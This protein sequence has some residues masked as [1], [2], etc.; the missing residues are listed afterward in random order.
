MSREYI[1]KTLLFVLVYI[2][3]TKLGLLLALDG[4]FATVVWPGSGLA[5]SLL[6]IYGNKMWPAIAIGAFSINFIKSGS[7]GMASSISLGNTLEALV[8]Y[9][10][11]KR[12]GDLSLVFTKLKSVINFIFASFT[13][14]MVSAII[15]SLTIFMFCKKENNCLETF[16]T[17]WLGDLT[18]CL[19]IV[20][21]I[22]LF[23]KS[24]L[25]LLHTRKTYVS[26]IFLI[27]SCY[28][29]FLGNYNSDI[30]PKALVYLLVIFPLSASLA[31]N[32]LSALIQVFII[33]LFAIWG[34]I[35]VKGPF[36]YS[37]LNH[38]LI[39]LQSFIAI[40]IIVTLI[41]SV[42]I[43][44]KELIEDKLSSLLKDKEILISEIHHRV[45]NNLAV[46]SSLLF[47]QRETIENEEIQKKLDQ[48]QLRI[49]TIA[50][51]HDKLNIKSNINSVEFSDY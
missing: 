15:G 46:V 37:E 24:N 39:V 25:S 13:G 21:I 33:L 34:T 35:E 4:G 11:M 9:N 28:L 6:L 7:I 48:T 3:S 10:I 42:G 47:L 29:I 5:L 8:A 32:R 1:V 49:K 30:I 45:K 36:I 19:I 43:K 14:S 26:F 17:W 2:I 38:S 18:S 41:V 40:L 20:P 27:L 23:S 44:E 50:L 31:Q 51:V 16:S 12:Y 22:L